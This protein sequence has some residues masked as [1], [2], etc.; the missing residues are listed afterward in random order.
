MTQTQAHSVIASLARGENPIDGGE[1]PEDSL[2]QDAAVIRALFI[3][4]RALAT[5]SPTEKTRRTQYANAGQA[6]TADDDRR[7]CDDY[8]AGMSITELAN[9]YE[10][11]KGAICSRLERLGKTTI[12]NPFY[13]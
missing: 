10:R 7:L 6:W 3:A 9:K 13:R 5:T 2:Y 12:N 1:L 11:S 4:E 8:D